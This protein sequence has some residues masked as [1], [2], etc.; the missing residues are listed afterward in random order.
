VRAGDAPQLTLII[1][2]HWTIL[3][4]TIEVVNPIIKRGSVILT[5]LALRCIGS[6]DRER[7]T[8]TRKSQRLL[9]ARALLAYGIFVSGDKSKR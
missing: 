6:T 3:V 2:A 8:D 4:A 1:E 9:D 5:Q 7:G